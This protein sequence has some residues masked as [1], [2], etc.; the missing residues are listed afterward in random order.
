M[1]EH[2]EHQLGTT[3]SLSNNQQFCITVHDRLCR[4]RIRTADV[5]YGACCASVWGYRQSSLINILG[6]EQQMTLIMFLY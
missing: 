5:E 6:S 3:W 2:D 1:Q 4:C